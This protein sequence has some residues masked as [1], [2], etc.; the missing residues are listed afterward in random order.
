MAAA[1][2]RIQ[3]N[4]KNERMRLYIAIAVILVAIALASTTLVGLS[5]PGTC[6]SIFP[7]Q[8]YNC[9]NQAAYS[10]S[11]L[12]MCST[13]P[14]QYSSQ[15]YIAIAENTKNDTA[16]G[17]ASDRNASDECV[18]FIA[19]ATAN[20]GL[21]T[22]LSPSMTQSCIERIEVST[23]TANACYTLPNNTGRISCVSAVYLAQAIIH[24]DKNYCARV[25]SNN[26]TNITLSAFG[27]LGFSP[28]AAYSG[29]GQVLSIA[30]IA[31][32]TFG[33]RDGCYASLA[34]V[35]SNPSYCDFA[36]N[37]TRSVC[38][39]AASHFSS[40]SYN[41]T[42]GLNFTEFMNLCQQ[43][44]DPALCNST[45]YYFKA[46]SA[47]NTS[48]CTVLPVPYSYQCYYTLAQIYNSTSYC[49]YITN[50][51]LNSQCVVAVGRGYLANI[52]G[53]G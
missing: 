28:G 47:R 15:C 16:C 1:G 27:M 44:A 22:G 23:G 5:K 21:C 20:P 8:N 39:L 50:A 11:N 25:P 24:R 53:T 3:S 13:L 10:T 9:I 42:A 14:A 7:S 19:N 46:V 26:N 40:V 17:L 48:T 12:S 34:Y 2:N 30:S 38:K 18:S 49:G 45:V 43:Q 33:V 6:S 4:L 35:S 52:T 41:A 29:V 32:I 37:S 51:T 36:S 31:N